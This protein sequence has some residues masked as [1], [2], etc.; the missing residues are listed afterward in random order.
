MTRTGRTLVM[1][2]ALIS[3]GLVSAHAKDL[4]LDTATFGAGG[5]VGKNFKIPGKNKCKP[6]AGFTLGGTYFVSGSGCTSASGDVFHLAIT[7]AAANIAFASPYTFSCT[8]PL[9]TLSGGTCVSTW[10]FAD[11][12]GDELSEANEPASA[13]VCSV[14]VP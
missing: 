7:A 6:F 1:A 14:D 9:P 4:C 12:P 11:S 8:L 2:I 3:M 13:A 5:I 10:A